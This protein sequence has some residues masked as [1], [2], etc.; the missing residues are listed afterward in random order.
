MADVNPNPKIPLAGAVE[1]L[2]RDAY[3]DRLAMPDLTEE[4]RG[5]V[6][7]KDKKHEKRDRKEGKEPV[8]M[9]EAVAAPVARPEPPP[10]PVID[11]SYGTDT[12]NVNMLL[13]GIRKGYVRLAQIPEE[14]ERIAQW[15][16][17]IHEKAVEEGKPTLAM[18]SIK[19]V[20]EINMANAEILKGLDKAARLDKGQP[21][22]I[23]AT[24]SPED[25][26]RIRKIIAGT[27][28]GPPP[29]LVARA[30]LKAGM[31]PPTTHAPTDPPDTDPA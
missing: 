12:E 14:A 1:D 16:I 31:Q 17:D 25:M 18:Q 30:A 21:T 10:K 11:T 9:P 29:E 28:G 7:R 22:S 15:A 3:L 26:E 5:T 8:R 2:D 19:L 13:S 6:A 23:T 4:D 20:N 24:K 27:R